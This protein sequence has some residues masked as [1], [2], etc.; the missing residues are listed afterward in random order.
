MDVTC[1][2]NVPHLKTTEVVPLTPQAKIT[3]QHL[4]TD[5]DNLTNKTQSIAH[6]GGVRKSRLKGKIESLPLFLLGEKNGKRHDL[7]LKDGNKDII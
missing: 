2:R 5:L 3:K 6:P 1:Q 7:V 4:T